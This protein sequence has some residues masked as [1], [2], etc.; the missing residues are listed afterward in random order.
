MMRPAASTFTSIPPMILDT[1]QRSVWP[2]DLDMIESARDRLRPFVPISP[3]RS[4]AVL[5]HE[6]GG[7]IRVSVKHENFNPT[8]S[9]KVRNGF[10]LMTALS[11]EE[12]Q[13]GVVAATRGN[14]GLGLAYAG[15]TFG[16]PVT[17]CVPLGNNPDKNAGIRALGARL[18]EEGL[19][20]DESM[21]AADRVVRDEGA[22]LA[23]STNNP[24]IIAG[25]G[26]LSLE[27]VEQEPALD[28]L[29]LS[30]GGGSQAVGAMTV[31]RAMRPHVRVYA[32]Q[33]AG[34]PASFESWR[35]GEPRVTAS[36]DTFADGLATRSSYAL[37]LPALREGL[38]DFITV[39]DAEIAHA[40]RLVL[41]TTHSLVEGAGAT[42][43]AG[44]IAL[45]DRLAGQR[46]GV[47][48]S[49]GNIDAS[50]LRRVINE[51]I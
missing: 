16:V 5:D 8:G 6:I 40:V 50:T 44:L 2:I 25:A 21:A 11:D 42:G 46:V 38:A 15:K 26:T 43:L 31:M 35:A 48:L 37:T 4:Y 41:R 49:G 3:L 22:V 23:H 29:V 10:S 45:R 14:H 28:A 17:I 34:A 32:V 30:V 33:A 19:D 12:R 13:R 7:G 51:E 27:I 36:A 39:T 1:L 9:F 20:Y 18:I 47:V 24:Y